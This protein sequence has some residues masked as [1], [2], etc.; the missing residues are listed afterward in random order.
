[1]ADAKKITHLSPSD[2]TPPETTEATPI[3]S[4]KSPARTRPPKSP[5]TVV[6]ATTPSG[7]D[8]APPAE[9]AQQGAPKQNLVPDTQESELNPEVELEEKEV[10]EA[11]ESDHATP[12]TWTTYADD[13]VEEKAEWVQARAAAVRANRETQAEEAGEKERV[14]KLMARAGLASRRGAEEMIQNGLV[15]VNGHFITEPGL[16][17]IPGVDR[18]VVDGKPLIISDKLATVILFHKPRNVMSTRDDP[19]KRTTV[20]NYL[21]HKFQRLFTVGRLDFDTSGVLLLTDDGELTHLLTHPSHGAEKT[22]EARVRGTVTIDELAQLRRGL[23][24]EDGPTAPCRAHVVAQREKNALVEITM[25]EGR[26][27]QVRRMLDA[28]SHPVSALRRTA[29]AGVELEGLPAGEH[30]VLL[31][32]EIKAL[33]KKVEGKPKKL[34]TGPPSGKARPK[35]RPPGKA[36]HPKTMPHP[37]SP[38]YQTMGSRPARRPA[39]VKPKPTNPPTPGFKLSERDS[40]RGFDTSGYNSASAE[41]SGFK[42][43]GPDPDFRGAERG[44]SERSANP[45]NNNPTNNKPT[46]NKPANRRPAGSGSGRPRADQNSPLADRVAKRWKS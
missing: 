43:S 32:G 18:I 21:P 19:G 6:E 8:A 24:L 38:A 29:F 15:S 2:S 37:S 16:K 35:K 46:N 28:I 39:P 36:T 20:F 14:S 1:M 13:Q 33:R 10:E 9:S 26:N 41:R 40:G 30:R 22:Y 11:W 27:R 4:K 25:R 3:T 17:A 31:L 12:E 7:E 45:T 23:T 44:R 34:K 5:A 42:Q